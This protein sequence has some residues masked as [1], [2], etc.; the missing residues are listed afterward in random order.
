MYRK[1]PCAQI[2]RS[3]QASHTYELEKLEKDS[4]IAT[5]NNLNTSGNKSTS[6]LLNSSNFDEGNDLF[7]EIK[8]KK[9]NSIK[10]ANYSNRKDIIIKTQ[11]D[12]ISYIEP[13]NL[14]TYFITFNYKYLSI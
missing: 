5:N 4:N 13:E 8:K 12:I 1:S 14:K 3:L 10:F 2:T 9:G 7:Y 6:S 11:S